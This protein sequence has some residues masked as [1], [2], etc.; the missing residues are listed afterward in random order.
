M[1]RKTIGFGG[2]CH[3]CTEAIFQS[4]IGV[5]K[6]EQGWIGSRPP[7]NELSEAVLVTFDP[8]IISLET[9]IEVHLLTHSCTSIHS[10]RGKYRSAIYYL[11]ANQKKQ[12]ELAIEKFQPTFDEP[13][14]TKVIP[15]KTFKLNQQQYLDYYAKNPEKPFC[16]TYISPKLTLLKRKY[17]KMIRNK[18]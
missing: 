5:D 4:L 11:D 1:G 15:F 6:V 8:K 12:A 18:I 14:I 3:W 16:Q 10:M 9:L 17:G 13:I 7:N 2:S